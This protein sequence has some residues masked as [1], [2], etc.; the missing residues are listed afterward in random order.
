MHTKH[1]KLVDLTIHNILSIRLINAS[2][3]D[4]HCVTRQLSASLSNS[5]T[6]PDLIIRFVDQLPTTVPVRYTNRREAG[7]ADDQYFLFDGNTNPP[8]KVSI[9]FDLLGLHSEIVCESGISSIPL[10]DSCVNFVA[11]LKGIVPLHAA[12]VR[13]KGSGVLMTAFPEGGKTSGLLAL[14][15]KGAQYISDDL[16]YAYNNTMYGSP[17]VLTLRGRHLTDLPDYKSKLSWK[18][19]L[20]MDIIAFILMTDRNLR[21]KL[22]LDGLLGSTLK[23]I[24]RIMSRRDYVEVD[25]KRLFL[26]DTE[27]LTGNLDNILILAS[28]DSS[29]MSA[30]PLSGDEL[31]ERVTLIQIQ[32]WEDLLLH[33]DGFRFA[34]PD[35]INAII[36][37]LENKIKETLVPI[38]QDKIGYVVYHPHPVS[39]PALFKTIEDLI[40]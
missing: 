39:V 14:V 3:E 25:P 26:V 32:D 13:Y 20:R 33:Y 18:Q 7:F 31:L 17:T 11:L 1:E 27:N 38:L 2:S 30:T 19:R 15:D 12:A 29:E 37:E 36:E 22:K 24:A 6:N 4:I 23:S 34:F 40:K 5:V 9:P 35:K 21:I 10:L 16:V 8:R 28:H